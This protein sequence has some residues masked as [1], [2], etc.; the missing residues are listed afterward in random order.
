MAS[1]VSTPDQAMAAAGRGA[2]RWLWL[3]AAV[4]V[5]DHL[6]KWLATQYLSYAEPVTL[7][8][9]FD[10]TLLHNTGAAFSFLAS[11]GGWQR[12]FFALVALGVSGYLV[13]WLWRTPPQQRW[14]ACAL[15]LILGGALGNLIDRVLLG[16]VVDFI[17][18]HW[19]HYYY[20]AFNIAD[21]AICVGAVMLLWDMFRPSASQP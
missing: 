18:L 13:H 1:S 16:Y 15:A 14:I 9:V 10:L 7:L 3:S 11:A 12:W 4:V 8:P 17:S 5:L 21:S 19:Q 20:P 2:I 6:T